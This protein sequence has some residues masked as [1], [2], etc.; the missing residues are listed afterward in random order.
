MVS[1]PAKVKVS[2]E[3][4]VCAIYSSDAPVHIEAV[5]E[6]DS[7]PRC[8]IPA[9]ESDLVRVVV[10]YSNPD[11]LAAFPN[12][13]LAHVEHGAKDPVRD[14]SGKPIQV[15]CHLVLS[16]NRSPTIGGPGPA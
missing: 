2:P 7:R 13:G 1:K 9:R 8:F 11:F 10:Q 4:D 15:R 12:V 16:Q 3:T 5:R 6:R 14:R